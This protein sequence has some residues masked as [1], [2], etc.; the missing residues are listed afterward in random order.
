[1]RVFPGCARWLAF[2]LGFG[3]SLACSSAE[4]GPDRKQADEQ[5]NAQRDEQT[6]AVAP[7]PAEPDKRERPSFD[8]RPPLIGDPAPPISL[9]TLTGERVSLPRSDSERATVLIFGS[10]TCPPF[11]M[12]TPGFEDLAVRWRDKAD[13]YIVFSREAH[14]KAAD[15]EPLGQAADQLIA[16]DRDGDNAV[17]LAEYQGPKAMF[18]PFD[19]DDDGEV[20]SYELLAARRLPQF[21]AI[22]APTSTA[23]RQALASRFRTDVPGEIPVLLDEIDN[24]T[25]VAYGGAPNSLF[26]ISPKGTI[27]H[28]FFWASTRDAERALAE[29][30]GEQPP[31]PEQRSVDWAVIEADVAAA[32]D[33]DKPVLLHFTALGCSACTAMKDKTLA[34]PRLEASLQTFHRVTLGIERDDTWRLF[35]A[36]DLSG[37]PAFVIVDPSTRTVVRKTQGFAD[38]EQFLGFLDG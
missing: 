23:E 21:E 9:D 13:F 3:L 26:V 2:G 30:F 7:K 11:R 16:Q 24:H 15:A 36:L 34:D 22:E 29:L 8:Q 27:S 25:S 32:R 4:R 35:E 1:M 28:K 20:R 12:K 6:E 17:T 33:A 31:E 5:T 10:F 38:G 14:P 18:E 19:L 37:T